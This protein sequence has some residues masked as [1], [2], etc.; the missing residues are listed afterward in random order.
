[1]GIVLNELLLSN[2]LFANTFLHCHWFSMSPCSSFHTGHTI[3]NKT[4][5][6]LFFL[7]VKYC[8]KVVMQ[9]MRRSQ[10]CFAKEYPCHKAWDLAV[11]S[12][13]RFTTEQPT[14]PRFWM[15]ERLHRLKLIK[16]CS[17][18]TQTWQVKVRHFK[19]VVYKQR[20]NID[21]SGT[22]YC[23]SCILY[24]WFIRIT[25]D[26][27]F[28]RVIRIIVIWIILV[29]LVQNLC[30]IGNVS[31]RFYYRLENWCRNN[32]THCIFFEPTVIKKRLI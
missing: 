5:I 6:F 21:L 32:G 28:I 31:T 24:A 16:A 26:V 4:N 30:C 10:P 25:Y 14:K 23:H 15:L 9:S 2:L 11:A 18:V 3:N 7:V 27:S 20:P 22:I 12:S 29:K 19:I 17:K 1:M 8:A 13:W